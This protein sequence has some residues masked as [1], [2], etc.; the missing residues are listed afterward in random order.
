MR[1]LFICTLLMLSAGRSAEALDDLRVL[2]ED[3]GT[4]MHDYL[5]GLAK[6]ALAERREKLEAIDS[7]DALSEWQEKRRAYFID[8]LGGFPDREALNARVVDAKNY[9]DF[10]LEKI[11]FESRPNFYVTALLYLPLSEGPHPAVLVPCG[12]SAN[13]KANETYQ[14]V[15]ILL[16]KHG[17][18]A[19]C[20]DPIGQGERY[21]VLDE[22][23]KPRFGSTTEH[24]FAGIG[25]MLL[26]TNT[27]GYRVWDGIRAI[28]YL[29][30]RD[31][32]DA[33][34]IGI[35]G[36]SGGGTLTSYLMA[37]DTRLRV[38]APSCYLTSFEKLLDTIGP[39]DAEQ[40]IFGQIEFGLDHADYLIMRA[41]RPT[42]VCAATH[43]F[44]SIEG[45]WDSYREAKRVYTTFGYPERL[46]I[47]EANEEH[48]FSIRLREAAVQWLQRWLRGIDKSV[49]ETGFDVF[50]DEE[51]Q[52]TPEGQVLLI[53]GALSVFDINRELDLRL[54]AHRLSLWR[55]EPPRRIQPAVR[56]A[57]GMEQADANFAGEYEVLSERQE[58]GYTLSKVVLRPE[59]GLTL[60]AVA[61]HPG[62]ASG[63]TYIVAYG[64]GFDTHAG[65]LDAW[66]KN[67]HAVLAVDL[68][69]MG[70]TAPPPTGTKAFDQWF[71]NG[72]QDFFVAYLLGKSYVGMRADDVTTAARFAEHFFPAHANRQVFLVATGAATVPAL[73]A[74]AVAPDRFDKV[75][76]EQG[77]VSW[78]TLLVNPIQP[79]ILE[80]AVHGALQLYDV[81]DLVRLLPE[82][83]LVLEK[84]MTT[85]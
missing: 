28:D 18:A 17:M 77:L 64:D 7:L 50:S 20:Y 60:P 13:G 36:N 24:T 52:V 85:D 74:A 56:R 65:Q 4:M 44:F 11:I 69:G 53:D 37:L 21:Q 35:T 57:V 67:G 15:C 76:L 49:T 41:P 68:R 10:R 27:A 63:I 2:S 75:R 8:Q 58:P 5:H 72:W 82:G 25:S 23:G 79:G 34:N 19:F 40:N 16:A 43:D 62:N 81:A 22:N 31:D 38:A 29:S 84:E 71:G 48:G 32:I 51:L 70:E 59:A 55:R 14:R 9:E 46:G 12:H 30:E 83:V 73:H 61:L 33:D 6:A 78:S 42:L 26:G 45:T 1:Q 47:A 66:A 54:Q 3:A 80:H 39:Q